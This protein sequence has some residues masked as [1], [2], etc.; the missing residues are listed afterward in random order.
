MIAFQPSR[1]DLPLIHSGD[2]LITTPYLGQKQIIIRLLSERLDIDVSREIRVLTSRSSQ[3]DEA[4]IVF[5]SFV[6]NRPGDALNLGFITA[7]KLINVLTTR[8]KYNLVL[9]GNFGE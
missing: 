7:P 4:P 8:A 5:V 9:F 3:G 2:I 1:K 6:S